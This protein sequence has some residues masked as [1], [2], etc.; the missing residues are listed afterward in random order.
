MAN[1]D[2]CADDGWP[3]HRRDDFIWVN[4]SDDTA[5]IS[6]NGAY[7]WPFTLPSPIDV[8]GRRLNGQ[9]GRTDCSIRSDITPG[10]FS[11]TVDICP[12]VGPR[13]VIIT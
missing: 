1:I 7:P 4:H 2:V 13:T 8:A 6:Q 12:T 11:Y 3:A 10:T 5:Q 9:P